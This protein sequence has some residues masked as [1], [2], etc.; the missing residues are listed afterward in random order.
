MAWSRVLPSCADRQGAF[1]LHSWERAGANLTD[2]TAG[3]LFHKMLQ[4][5]N[6]VLQCLQDIYAARWCRALT[7]RWGDW[8]C[9][10]ADCSSCPAETLCVVGVWF[11]LLL[12]VVQ[13]ETASN[14]QTGWGK[15]NR[16]HRTRGA[17]EH[18]AQ[19]LQML[20]NLHWSKLVAS[21]CF[22]IE[23]SLTDCAALVRGCLWPTL[24]CTNLSWSSNNCPWW[25]HYRGASH[26]TSCIY[27][28]CN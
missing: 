17:Q 7:R 21:R 12:S 3:I 27:S 23:F 24:G 28:C 11:C 5:Q 14:F 20:W 6:Y 1:V 25:R 22:E 8:R 18:N 9:R 26:A 10:P 19:R 15:E 13:S 4:S 2:Q 16:D